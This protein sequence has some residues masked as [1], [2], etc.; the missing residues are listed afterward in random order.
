METNEEELAGLLEIL[1]TELELRGVK[2]LESY[3]YF[4]LPANAS[5]DLKGAVYN[6]KLVRDNAIPAHNTQYLVA[7]LQLSYEKLTGAPLA[8][9]DLLY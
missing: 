1:Q 4:E 6:F 8:S 9:A 2:V 5:V 7:L 3:P